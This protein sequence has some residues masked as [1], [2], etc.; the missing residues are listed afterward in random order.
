PLCIP[1]LQNGFVD[2]T[3]DQALLLNPRYRGLGWANLSWMFTT[4]HM[5]HYQ[6][7]S[8]LTLGVDHLLWG[9]APWGYHLTNLLLH[10]SNGVLFYFVCLRL[11]RL[12]FLDC[13]GS[14]ER[15]LPTASAVAELPFSNH[16]FRGESVACVTVR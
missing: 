4:L 16:P 12:V 13:G 8:W 7:L 6:P 1:S 2:F 10:A 5:G 15:A 14:D 9:M 3:D 11:L